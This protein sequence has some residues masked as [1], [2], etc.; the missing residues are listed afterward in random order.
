MSVACFGPHEL[1]NLCAACAAKTGRPVQSFFGA[2]VRYSQDNTACFAYQYKEEEEAEPVEREELQALLP[3]KVDFERARLTARLLRYNLV[4]NSGRDFAD[5]ESL[6]AC[7]KLCEAVGE[8]EKAEAA[9]AELKAPAC[10]ADP[11]VRGGRCSNCGTWV[12]D[13]SEMPQGDNEG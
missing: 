5:S 8:R 6:D 1:A 4:A 9:R 10:C 12:S 13:G 2:A 11:E 7:V 3:S